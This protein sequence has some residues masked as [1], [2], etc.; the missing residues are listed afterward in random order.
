VHA[1]E[2]EPDQADQHADAGGQEHD[3]VGRRFRRAT[4]QVVGQRGGKDRRDEGAEVDAH[5]EDGE[6]GVAAL[7]AGGIQLATIV[8]IFGLNRPLPEM[9]V[10]RPSV[11]IC[12]L[13]DRH[14]EQAERHD[15]GAEQDGA[16]VAQDLVGD[17]AA[18]DRRRVH[19]REVGAV[20]LGGRL[21]ARTFAAVELGDDVQHERPAD[22]VEREALPE[23]RH[24]QHPQRAW[25]AHQLLE[26]GDIPA[27]GGQVLDC[28]H[29]KDSCEMAGDV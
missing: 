15:H 25:M 4:H 24:E 27:L 20:E 5:V 6:A 1:A 28:A 8:E 11:K 7:V 16:L 3:L 26:F 14:H 19:Q 29:A 17:V 12:W 23:F 2:P 13:G 10:A 21:L 22:A 18:E 9:I